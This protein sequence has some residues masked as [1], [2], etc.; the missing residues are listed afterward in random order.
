MNVLL[1]A[2]MIGVALAALIVLCHVLFPV[3]MVLLLIGLIRRVWFGASWSYGYGGC[4][5][6]VRPPTIDGGPWLH[7]HGPA[8]RGRDVQWI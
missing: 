3:L 5:G 2:V 6:G 7:A 1:K 8:T 4:G